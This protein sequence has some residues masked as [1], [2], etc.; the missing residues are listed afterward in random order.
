MTQ[1]FDCN[2]IANNNTD[3]TIADK[4][5]NGKIPMLLQ[6]A[7]GSFVSNYNFDIDTLC[8]Q[9]YSFKVGLRQLIKNISANNKTGKPLNESLA[10]LQNFIEQK[11]PLCPKEKTDLRNACIFDADPFSY[12][13]AN[14]MAMCSERAALSQ[15]VL[16][17]CGIKSYYVNSMA[18]IQNV[19]D[20]PAHHAYIMINDNN[21]ILVYD[22][23]N[24]RPND[25]PR[26][27]NTNMDSAIFADFIDAVN[28]NAQSNDNQSKK[29]VGFRCVDEQSGKNFAYHSLC[30][31]KGEN[32]TPSKLK[33]ARVLKANGD[34]YD[35]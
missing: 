21:K 35:K 25:Q 26:I 29:R 7:Q 17:N 19:T 31:K 33:A 24:P 10:L 4:I 13:V 11:L 22:P 15:Y 32:I 6:G 23:A 14:K 8:Q 20:K 1:Q 34:S 16:Q 27:L 18:Q 12:L 3:F 2:I 30:G 9:D 28:Y 5:T